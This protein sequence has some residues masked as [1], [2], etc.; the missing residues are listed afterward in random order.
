MFIAKYTEQ[1][2]LSAGGGA[3]DESEDIRV[4][5]YAFDTAYDMIEAGEIKDAKT[6]ILLQ[7]L[8][9]QNKL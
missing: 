1:E 6:V 9:L 2:K 3:V 5:E 8:K 4:L 7:Y